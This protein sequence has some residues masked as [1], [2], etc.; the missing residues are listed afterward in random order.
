MPNN[1]GSN[2]INYG[3]YTY[4][5]N[6]YQHLESIYWYG[7]SVANTGM[8]SSIIIDG[9]APTGSMFCVTKGTSLRDINGYYGTRYS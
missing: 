6:C 9:D 3:G 1:S 2:R 7:G 8:W 4:G 5:N